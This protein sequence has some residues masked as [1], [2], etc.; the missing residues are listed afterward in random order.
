[1]LYAVRLR[2]WRARLLFAVAVMTPVAV[3][4]ALTRSPV[5]RWRLAVAFA[6]VFVALGALVRLWSASRSPV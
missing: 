3:C 1:V 4:T 2:P 6:I 5:D